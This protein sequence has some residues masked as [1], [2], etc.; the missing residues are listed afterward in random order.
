MLSFLDIFGIPIQMRLSK[1]Q[2]HK[3]AFGSLITVIIVSV[4]SVYS[5]YILNQCF[6]Y[7]NPNI[8]SQDY[9]VQQPDEV[10]FD[11]QQYTIAMGIQDQNLVHFLDESIYYLEVQ[12][13]ET[14]KIYNKTT[15]LYDQI[16]VAESIKMEPCTLDHF[17]VN[18]TID[19]FS[20]LKFN[21]IYC[22]PLNQKINLAGQFGAMQY[23]RLYIQV[24][25]CE[26]NCQNQTVIQQKLSDVAFQ[27]YYV[28]YIISPNDL[29]NPFKPI[30]Q[31]TFWQSGYSLFKNIN[32]YFRKN[33]IRTDYGLISQEF[34]DDY[35]MIYSNDRETL[36]TK[37]DNKLYE[38]YIGLEKNKQSEYIRTYL[39]LFSAISQIG[40]VYNVFFLLGAL[41]CFPIQRISLYYKLLNSLFDFKEN[42]E[43]IRF[44]FLSNRDSISGESKALHQKLISPSSQNTKSINLE[45]EI[46]EKDYAI[47][48]SIQTSTN[49]K[50]KINIPY[51][52]KNGIK[53]KM[54][55]ESAEITIQQPPHS[56]LLNTLS[57]EDFQEKNLRQKQHQ[58]QLQQS[59]KENQQRL[60]DSLSI[61]YYIERIFDYLFQSSPKISFNIF[62]MVKSQIQKSMNLE[63]PYSKMINSS[64]DRLQEQLDLSYILKKIQDIEKLKYLLLNQN[65][66]KLFDSISKQAFY[67][68]DF[69][70]KSNNEPG[71]NNNNDKG[72]T[73]CESLNQQEQN[74]FNQQFFLQDKPKNENQIGRQAQDAFKQ[75][76]QNGQ[77]ISIIDKKL[78]QLLTSGIT[79]FDK[80]GDIN[81]SIKNN[82]NTHQTFLLDP[83]IIDT[84]LEIQR[85]N[86][87]LNNEVKFS[88]VMF[89]KQQTSSEKDVQI[90]Q[91]SSPPQSYKIH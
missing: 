35:R 10:V 85:Q 60:N 43:E 67:L 26:I 80:E 66:I 57:V 89:L 90:I 70:N 77:S 21:N 38:I 53:H 30:G 73:R 27:L 20:S 87:N 49:K 5:F 11:Q 36:I 2:K 46:F 63:K 19:Y 51:V 50:S 64:I 84:N 7:S 59:I 68:S 9:I 62:K 86:N 52:S 76:Y 44:Q 34:Q 81:Q 23:K 25:S 83:Q 47:Q 16:T 55:L 56:Y 33:T 17:Q 79:N 28:N 45:K 42:R 13:L 22:F 31:N 8:V 74:Q 1:N 71:Q 14:T 65:Q 58:Q 40:G 32:V 39:K 48:N 41:I 3:T 15:N 4:V 6:Q 29:N 69:N 91:L 88:Q 61:K 54:Q 12:I 18:Q 37:T 24:K 72:I 78:L 82:Y 75:I